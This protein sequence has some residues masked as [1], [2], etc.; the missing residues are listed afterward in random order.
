MRSLVN[1]TTG[2]L[3]IDKNWF[4]GFK[5][6]AVCS[7]TGVFVNFVITPGDV[8]DITQVSELSN[9]LP[10]GSELIGDK[11]YISEARQLDLFERKKVKLITPLRS[12][13][14]RLNVDWKPAKRK[15][16]K[17]IETAFS[18]V[19]DF[20]H[21]KRNYTKEV[22]GFLARISTKFAAFTCLQFLNQENGRPLNQLKNAIWA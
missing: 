21:I 7:D 17:R 12:N 5:I 4:A 3:P 6:H 22:Q 20:L 14:R 1:R 15:A 8:H 19:V 16:R 2:Y 13:Q 11:G 18:Q 9:L 10:E